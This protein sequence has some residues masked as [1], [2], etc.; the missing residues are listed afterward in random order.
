MEIEPLYLN[1]PNKATFSQYEQVGAIVYYEPNGWFI[2][3]MWDMEESKPY[4]PQT[5]NDNEIYCNDNGEA[6]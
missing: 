6:K 1:I 4:I 2:M 5:A 3:E